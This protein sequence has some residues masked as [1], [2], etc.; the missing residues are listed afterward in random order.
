VN[1][2]AWVLHERIVIAALAALLVTTLVSLPLTIRWWVA[3]ARGRTGAARR[4]MAA[5]SLAAVIGGR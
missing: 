5:T 4:S 3:A 2:T 1:V